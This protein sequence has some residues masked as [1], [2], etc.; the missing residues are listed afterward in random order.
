[1]EQLG[2]AQLDPHGTLSG[3]PW[4]ARVIFV[5]GGIGL[6]A[7][8]RYAF[9]D[10]DRAAAEFRRFNPRISRIATGWTGRA[11]AVVLGLG[12]ACFVLLAI[13]IR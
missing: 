11:A 9:R 8:G 7:V 5:V 12:G 2:L 3:V 10:A 1:L 4:L 13:L 6:L